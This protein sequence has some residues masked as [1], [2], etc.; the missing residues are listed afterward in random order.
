MLVNVLHAPKGFK[1]Q[2]E[3]HEGL[4]A[5]RLECCAAEHAPRTLPVGVPPHTAVWLRIHA[6]LAYLLPQS[7][8]HPHHGVPGRRHPHHA[9]GG[10]L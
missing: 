6:G 4:L 2:P 1:P 3:Y 9:G 8:P 7:Q 10:A 5:L